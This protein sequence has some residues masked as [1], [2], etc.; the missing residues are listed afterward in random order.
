MYIGFSNNFKLSRLFQQSHIWEIHR[1]FQGIFVY[2]I[3]VQYMKTLNHS[4]DII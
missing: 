1:W 2:V 4:D 3:N